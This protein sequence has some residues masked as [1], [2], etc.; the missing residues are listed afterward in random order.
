MSELY[1]SFHHTLGGA[2]DVC[3]RQV[4][5][6]FGVPSSTL[7]SFSL[8]LTFALTDVLHLQS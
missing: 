6:E 8:G 3:L 5:A 1:A 4:K 2:V 7:T